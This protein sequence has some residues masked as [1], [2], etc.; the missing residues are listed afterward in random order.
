MN[1]DQAH[2]VAAMTGGHL[3]LSASAA[4]RAESDRQNYIARAISIGV[5]QRTAER[6]LAEILEDR[7]RRGLALEPAPRIAFDKLCSTDA[8]VSQDQVL[9]DIA[10]AGDA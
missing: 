9:A 3:A 7:S 5:D 6:V 1:L 2:T 8:Y 10:E 4:V